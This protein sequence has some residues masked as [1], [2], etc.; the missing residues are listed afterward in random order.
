[1]QP[2]LSD[3]EGRAIS[4]LQIEHAV[5]QVTDS[6]GGLA[7]SWWEAL[8]QVAPIYIATHIAFLALTYLAALFS[9]R[10]FST[11]SLPLNTLLVSWNR[12]DTSQFTHIAAYGY[13]A[14]YRMAFFPLFPLLE[15]ILAVVV[16]DPF[17]AGLLISNLATL[18]MFM[19]FYRLVVE[20]FGGVRAWHSVL[21][22]AIFPTAFFFAAAYN[23]SLFIFFS[24]LS[25]YY[26][27]KGRWWLAGLAALFASLTRSIAICLLIP[28]AYEYM[29]QRDFQWRRIGF[30]VMSGIGIIGGI[31]LFCLYGYLKFHDPLAFMHAQ[32]VWHRQ[33][34]FPWVVFQVAYRNIRTHPILSFTSIHTVMDLSA[35]LFI[36]LMLVLSFWGPWKFAREQWSYAF[37]ACALY[38]FVILTPEA[39]SAALS[40]LSRFMLEIFPAFITVAAPGKRRD[41]NLYYLTICLP[42]L[43]FMVLQWLTGKWIV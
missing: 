6:N 31:L 36:L 35:I 7:C 43:G 39:A 33:L 2:S 42:L 41:F 38:L 20:D 34:T 22:L 40:S 8:K 5:E 11:S 15:R 1:M 3:K 28:F 25:F 24:I 19:V 23:E 13:D 16:R 30:S 17:I 21:Y 12:W 37:Y 10:N 9:L 4:P 18:S 32:K 14:S 29:R 27:R 26:M